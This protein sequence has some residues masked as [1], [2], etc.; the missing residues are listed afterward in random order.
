MNI[1]KKILIY[2][3]IYPYRLK[4]IRK[5]EHPVR[6]IVHLALWSLLLVI[7]FPVKGFSHPGDAAVVRRL[8]PSEW[9]FGVGLVFGESTGLTGKYWLTGSTAIDGSLGYSF[10]DRFRMN[11]NYLVHDNKAFEAPEFSLYYGI[12]GSILGGEG[13]VTRSRVGNFGIGVRGVLGVTYIFPRAPLDT[14]LEIAPVLVFAPPI[15]L[16]IDLNLGIRVYP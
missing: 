7:Y 12:G 9:R 13:Y 14:F 10:F 11:I 5:G 2:S 3:V 8:S 1:S 4:L 6:R 16:A 15:G